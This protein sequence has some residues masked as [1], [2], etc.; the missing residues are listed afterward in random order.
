[1]A[2]LE[3]TKTISVNYKYFAVF[4]ISNSVD[5]KI[6]LLRVVLYV[7]FSKRINS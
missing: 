7:S 5:A 1:M 6:S 4:K 3:L 2:R